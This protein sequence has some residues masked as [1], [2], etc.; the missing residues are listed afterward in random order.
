MG[1]VVAALVVTLSHLPPQAVAAVPRPFI[2][3]YGHSDNAGVTDAFR[4]LVPRIN[5][6]E[7]TS[8]N[9]MFIKELR[10]QKCIYAAHVNSPP[11]ASLD[12]LVNRWRAPFED[13]LGA[14]CRADTTRSQLTNCE[15]TR[16]A[17]RNRPLSAKR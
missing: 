2:C 11:G 6:I 4:K 10:R 3:M 1:L 16:M 17:V 14:S 15:P 9:A 13:D 7:G 8:R 5:V 12:E